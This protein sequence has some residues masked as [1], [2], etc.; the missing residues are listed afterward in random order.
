MAVRYLYTICFKLNC[1]ILQIRAYR[2]SKPPN[3]THFMLKSLMGIVIRCNG[4]KAVK[5]ALWAEVLKSNGAAITP[6]PLYLNYKLL[7]FVGRAVVF[8]LVCNSVLSCYAGCSQD[9]NI[10]ILFFDFEKSAT[11]MIL[12]SCKRRDNQES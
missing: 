1:E 8:K 7:L 4:A 10:G 2:P 3:F 11:L 12:D 9:I 6:V 5:K